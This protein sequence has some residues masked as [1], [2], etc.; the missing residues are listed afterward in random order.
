MKKVRKALVWFGVR[1]GLMTG[2]GG[3]EQG[4]Q[5]ERCTVCPGQ[6]GSACSKVV[7][8]IGFQYFNVFS[9]PAIFLSKFFIWQ[10][11]NNRITASINMEPILLNIRF[12]T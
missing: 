4:S 11:V 8:F 10:F 6:H 2:E 1:P 7:F 3:Q 9:F 12:I 5:T